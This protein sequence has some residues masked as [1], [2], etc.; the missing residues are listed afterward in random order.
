VHYVLKGGEEALF[1]RSNG[2]P[3][4]RRVTDCLK[5]DL[6]PRGK[7]ALHSRRKVR[8]GCTV[9]SP[10][11]FFSEDR[12]RHFFP[13]KREKKSL[14]VIQKLQTGVG[15]GASLLFAG[16]GSMNS[17]DGNWLFP[18]PPASSRPERS[19]P[20]QST[21]LGPLPLSSS[22]LLSPFTSHFPTERIVKI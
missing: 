7:L 11:L 8:R 18:P 19:L 5:V 4:T 2:F 22:P 10:G 17:N 9:Q 14:L 13:F 3:R 15:E 20:T 16:A 21:P 1:P 6:W 12:L